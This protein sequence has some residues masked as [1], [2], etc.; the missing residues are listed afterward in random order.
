M[1]IDKSMTL[2]P[3]PANNEK[4]DRNK[5]KINRNMILYEHGKINKEMHRQKSERLRKKQIDQYSF[6]PDIDIN[7]KRMMQDNEYG[8]EYKAPKIHERLYS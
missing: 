5:N 8:D 2:F 6:H 7:S 3:V 1:T 4:H